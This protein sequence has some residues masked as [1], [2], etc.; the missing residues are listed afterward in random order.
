MLQKLQKLKNEFCF[1]LQ[2]Q[3]SFLAFVAQNWCFCIIQISYE[4]PDVIKGVEGSIEISIDA[5]EPI[6]EVQKLKTNFVFLVTHLGN[7][8]PANAKSVES[9]YQYDHI[10]LFLSSSPKFSATVLNEHTYDYLPCQVVQVGPS[11][12]GWAQEKEICGMEFRK[13]GSI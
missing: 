8:A 5:L 13:K 11:Y 6:F 7:D 9:V 1:S 3:N 10:Y 12:N 2:K 4:P